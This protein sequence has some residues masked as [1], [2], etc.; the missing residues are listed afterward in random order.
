M[1]E[2]DTRA[3]GY[4]KGVMIAEVR[5]GGAA[6]KAGLQGFRVDP[7]TDRQ[8]PGD[9]IL[10]VDGEPVNTIADFERALARLRVGQTITLILR[11]GDETKE[12]RVTLEGI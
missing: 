8:T 6:A 10:A 5:P 11:R 4:E 3:L 12:V 1:P 7:A 9:V 2:E